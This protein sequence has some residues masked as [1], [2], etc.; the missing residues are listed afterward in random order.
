MLF[1]TKS[2]FVGLPILQNHGVG[3]VRN[4]N[5]V[6]GQ[7]GVLTELNEALVPFPLL[8]HIFPNSF[9][10]RQMLLVSWATQEP[11]ALGRMVAYYSRNFGSPEVIY[12][13][14]GLPSR[15]Q[16]RRIFKLLSLCTQLRELD[17]SCI[18]A[19]ALLSS[20]SPGHQARWLGRPCHY[21]NRGRLKESS[22]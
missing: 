19:T 20:R 2:V 18:I 11:K 15:G 16:T 6:R 9:H 21:L 10:I 14:E 7:R 13:R 3:W 22:S 8:G 17:Q 4:W 5:P 1:Y 12:C